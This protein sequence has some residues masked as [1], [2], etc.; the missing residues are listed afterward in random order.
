M[1]V[2]RSRMRRSRRSPCKY[3]RKK[4]MRHGC[5]SK[6]GPKRRRSRRTSRKVARR[7]RRRSRKVARRSRRRSRKVVRRSIRRSRRSPCKY[8][9]KK[10]GRKGCKSKSGPKR[11]RSRRVRR[12]RKKYGY[13]KGMFSKMKKMAGKVAYAPV[14]GAKAVGR[15][16]ASAAGAVANVATRGY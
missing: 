8:G 6:P 4:S 5:K 14:R 7:S 2:R 9:R 11:R 10:S 12:S 13:R 3:G 1:A 16:V 15:G